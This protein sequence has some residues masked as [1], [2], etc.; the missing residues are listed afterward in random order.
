M[1][2]DGGAA[3]ACK[4]Q[5]LMILLLVCAIVATVQYSRLLHRRAAGIRVQPQRAVYEL[6]GAVERPG[7][8]RYTQQQ[9]RSALAAACGAYRTLPHATEQ[10]VPAGTCL[11]F[12]ASGVALTDMGAP[13]LFSFGLPLSLANACAEDLE[14]IP[15]IGPA[16]ARAM[17]DYRERAGPL[18]NIEQLLDVRG[19]GPRTLEKITRYLRP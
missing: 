17:I 15:G 18:Q 11:T 5:R 14:L 4:T 8:Y 6:R 19:I 16:T 3:Q 12:T 7:I 10:S 1:A 13:A 9:P 2:T